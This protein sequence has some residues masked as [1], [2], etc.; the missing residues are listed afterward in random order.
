MAKDPSREQLLPELLALREKL[1]AAEQTL[2]EHARVRRESET[3][4]RRLVEH[5]P[6]AAVF[7]E[8]QQ[9]F[10]NRGAEAITGYGRDE[11]PT[12]DV[13]MKKLH[14][15]RSEAVR[16]LFARERL[17]GARRPVTLPITRPGGSER[18]VEITA[19]VEQ[20]NE[21]WLLRDVT[22]S[23]RTA[24]LMAQGERGARI[25]AWELDWRT[26]TMHWTEEAYRLHGV[27]PDIFVPSLKGMLGFYV[28]DSAAQL[29]EAIRRA[30]ADG[31][32]F[33]LELVMF[34]SGR[35]CVARLIG[36]SE[37]DS[38]RAIRVFGSVQDVT[39]RKLAADALRESEERLAFALEASGAAVWDEN[40]QTGRILR[41]ARWA[42]ML[43]YEPDEVGD[44]REAWLSRLHP[45]DRDAVLEAEGRHH[46]GTTSEFEA[47]YR[48]RCKDGSYRWVLDR[49]RVLTR[50]AEGRPLREVG[51]LTDINERKLAERELRR[52][53]GDLERGVA[54]R[55]A[56]IEAQS[57]ALRTAYLRQV[58]L[59]EALPDV[60]LRVRAD[61][62]LVD[63]S[64]PPH[65][66]PR[67][68]EPVRGGH[69]R[70]SQLPPEVV[71]CILEGLPGALASGQPTLLRCTVTSPAPTADM[72]DYGVR[73]VP[74]S[75]DEAVAIVQRR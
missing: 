1:D 41:S 62:T 58:A 7:A 47:E 27:T 6:A 75:S 50:S 22:E 55:T 26:M 72:H 44:D 28:P 29:G 51:T 4:L 40:P 49:G 15:G 43:G 46:N 66:D 71:A 69:L 54:Q 35:Y 60:L 33:D 5:L 8:G 38:G 64:V 34:T 63:L 37:R 36:Q 17:S 74:N 25:G 21:V 65:A 68:A 20:D 48:L 70:L 45:E 56:A 59:L 31:Q 24:R 19:Y 9:L 2:S 73:I 32:A 14:P 13:W 11:L 18:L 16:E 10:L 42:A 53:T 61:G 23:A 67:F 30:V 52:L 39:E 3:R 57:A 12:I